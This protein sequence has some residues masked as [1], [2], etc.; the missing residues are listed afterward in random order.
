M[1]LARVAFRNL[2]R[3]KKRS[4]LL[5]GAIAFGVVIITV[6]NGLTGGFIGNASDNFSH[7]LA[8][9]IFVEGRE[10]MPS[11]RVVSVIRDDRALVAA[12]EGSSLAYEHLMRRASFT[13]T[14][15]FEGVSLTLRVDGVDWP[16]ESYLRERLTL[17]KGSWEAVADPRTVVLSEEIARQLGA[18]VGDSLLVSLRTVTGQQ[19]AGE[20]R[21][22]AVYYDPGLLSTV[23]AYASLEAVSELLGLAPGEYMTLGILLP[24]IRSME[25]DVA[26]YRE[27]L[28]QAGVPLLPR[29]TLDLMG[30]GFFGSRAPELDWQGTRFQVSTLN[31]TLGQLNQ[32]VSILNVIGLVILLV[33]FF[34]IM[35]GITNTYR[36]I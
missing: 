4:F 22:G 7:L 8:G 18:E 9:H 26:R 16:R 28:R 19:N 24:D 1:N 13:G 5:G 14:L 3:Q 17:R 35:V 33:L 25:R 36:M 31:D 23:S 29:Q 12:L 15:I 32:I 34:I 30:F 27:A 10:K 20:L 11:G 2:N 6:I 21:L